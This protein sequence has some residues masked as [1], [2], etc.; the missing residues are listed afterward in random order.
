MTDIAAA[1]GVSQVERLEWLRERRN[2]LAR[3]YD[4]ALNGLPLQLPRVMPENVSAFH[5]YVVRLERRAAHRA[6]IG[7]VFE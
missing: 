2:V 6:C 4:V 3:R 7:E 1:L 5:M